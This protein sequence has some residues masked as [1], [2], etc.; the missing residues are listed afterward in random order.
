MILSLCGGVGFTTGRFVLS[1]TLL[2]SVL[3][4]IVVISLGKE[5]AG[6]CASRAFVYLFCTRQFLSFF[7]SSWCQK[8]AAAC[9][10]DTPWI[11][12]LFFV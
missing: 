3:F 6:L 2:C 12:L 7:P 5:R 8:L 11:F 10:C 4:S 1:H 9:D